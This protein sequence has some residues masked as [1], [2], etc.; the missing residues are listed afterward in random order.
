MTTPNLYTLDLVNTAHDREQ[1]RQ[2]FNQTVNR[3][4]WAH[5]FNERVKGKK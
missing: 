5:I 3:E 1:L 2:R 4:R